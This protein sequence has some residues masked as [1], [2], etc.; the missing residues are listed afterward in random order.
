MIGKAYV[1]TFPF[2]NNQI[3]QMQFKNRP[4]LIIGQA[5]SSDYIVLPISRITN[6][7]NI[8]PYYDHMIT[9]QTTPL[10][11]L[12]QTSYIRTHKQTVINI[13]SLTKMIVDFRQEYSDIYMEVLAKVEEFQKNVIDSAL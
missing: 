2:Y 7:V 6:S 12:K 5:D 9:I 1:A 4:V 10:M 11:N 8:D 13:A 3:H